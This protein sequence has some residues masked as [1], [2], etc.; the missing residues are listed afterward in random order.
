[1]ITVKDALLKIKQ[2]VNDGAQKRTYEV[3]NI[4][5]AHGR[6]LAKAVYS[7]CDLPAFRVAT[8]HGYAVLASDG[9]G[10]RIVL[11]RTTVS[12]DVK[13]LYTATG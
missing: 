2:V 5:N 12:C 9:E 8:K 13:S 1:M 11:H 7:S 10:T 3:I 4:N 6:I